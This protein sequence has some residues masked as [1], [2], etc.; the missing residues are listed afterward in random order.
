MTAARTI[1]HVNRAS[2]LARLPRRRAAS[3]KATPPTR[4]SVGST[5]RFQSD[6][7]WQYRRWLLETCQSYQRQQRWLVQR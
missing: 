3:S 6:H 5:V 2:L 7:G 1:G 4:S